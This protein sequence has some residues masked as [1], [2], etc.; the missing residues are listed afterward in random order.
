MF[1]E[2]L[3]GKQTLKQLSLKYDRSIPW[4][5]KQLDAFEPKFRVINPST[6][7]IVADATFYGKKSDRLGTLVFKDIMNDKIV[8]SKHI[9]TETA[10]D[11]KQLLY[12]LLEQGFTIHGVTIDGKRGIA[13]AFGDIPIQMCHF[14]QI[15]IIK[16]YL[17]SN[18]KLEPSIELL[19]ICKRIPTTTEKKFTE[20]LTQWHQKH[21][22]FL[23]EK[24]LNQATSRYVPTHAKLV[25]AHR[26]LMTNL[27]YLFTYKNHKEFMMHN[28]TN[29]LD[30][31]VF[32]QLK[33]LI[34]L[35]QG[36]AKK[37]DKTSR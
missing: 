29:A 5:K 6:I 34:K 21:K 11:Y 12:E 2:Y 4:I 36:L 24:T 10:A 8:A 32:T 9:E 15:A 13:R 33:K 1:Q 19:Q 31:G 37:K 27:P 25:S 26:S 14:H 20:Y 30:G 7:T 35:H 17:T 16:R 23:E 28:T 18:P 22:V 3:L